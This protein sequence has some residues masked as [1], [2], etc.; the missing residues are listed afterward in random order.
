MTVTQSLVGFALAAGLLTLTP[1]L[2]TAL[3]LRSAA[4]DGRRRAA[5]VALGV[6]TGCLAWGV[7]A[8]FGLGALITASPAGYAALRWAGAAYLVWL[9]VNLAARPRDSFETSV[10]P[11]A[12]RGVGGDWGRGLMT[13][14]LNPKV[15]V[16]Y[17]SFLPQF[18]PAGV[19]P[20]PFMLLL[21]AIHTA[22]GIA[23][24]GAL[25]GATA[26]LR[27]W[28]DRRPVIRWLDRITGG[29]LI[30]FGLRLA[31]EPGA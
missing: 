25:I 26:P 19:A 1:G 10:G 13:N 9:G 14:A 21:A 3:V 5:A 7:L 23:W 8:A 2:D 30:G 16:F 4:A 6:V 11:P 31:F 28:L 27:R 17:V 22:F 12:S 15:G 24:F 29:V 18:V 20:A